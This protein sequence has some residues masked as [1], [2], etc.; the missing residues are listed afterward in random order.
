MVILSDKEAALSIAG[1]RL[2][3]RFL[4][5]PRT[6]IVTDQTGTPSMVGA[7]AIEDLVGCSEVAAPESVIDDLCERMNIGDDRLV[8]VLLRLRAES[9]DGF[10]K[11][12][13][14]SVRS[15]AINEATVRL[16]QLLP[17][18]TSVTI[19]VDTELD[20]GRPFS[21]VDGFGFNRS[22]RE[23]LWLPPNIDHWG[24]EDNEFTLMELIGEVGPGDVDIESVQVSDNHRET[25]GE[26]WKQLDRIVEIVQPSKEYEV[27][28]DRSSTYVIAQEATSSD[29]EASYW[30]NVNGWGD[31]SEATPFARADQLTVNLPTGNNVKWVVLSELD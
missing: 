16:W 4:G 24:E 1:L 5:E 23:H 9:H 29:G 18:L 26:I 8:D 27:F 13:L 28:L 25:F 19:E 7:E 10:Y 15:L 6:C 22:T 20:C 31:L 14:E 17:G 21:Y 30:S 12:V 3:Q 11:N 2:L